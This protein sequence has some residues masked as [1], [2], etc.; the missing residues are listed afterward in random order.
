[1]TGEQA[2][3]PGS[4]A[5]RGVPGTR[6][7]GARRSG[8][9]DATVSGARR[10]ALAAKAAR[11]VSAAR[12]SSLAGA[13]VGV[14]PAWLVSRLVVLGTLALAHVLVDRLHP[15]VAG[16]AARVHGGLLGWDAG[17]YEAIARSGYRPSAPGSLRF[18]P[19]VPL[20]ARALGALPGVGAGTA[21]LV[22]ANAS[23]WLGLAVVLLLVTR[24][25]GDGGTARRAVW[26]LAL[27]PA[28]FTF[29]MGYAE[30]TLLVLVA[31]TFLLLRRGRWWWAAATGL[32]AGLTRPIG[33]LLVVPAAI[34][35]TRGLWWGV[36][37]T[38]TAR[39]PS[40]RAAAVLGPLAGTGAYLAWVG[41]VFGDALLPLRV[42]QEGGHRGRLADPLRTL[43]H[44]TLEA[45]HGHHVGSALH[46]PWVLLAVALLVVSARR[47]PASYAAFAGAVL[48]LA[49]TASNLD[50]FER[51]ALS[52]IP[53]TLA[54]ASITAGGVV[55]R[56]VLVL[57]A[58]SLV[59]YALLAFVNLYVP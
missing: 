2:P 39:A 11:A 43:A 54:A 9:V 1:M 57:L 48:L 10:S 45:L 13:L 15:A 20:A 14:A 6:F 8:P 35:A 5:D 21:L 32:L 56:T 34:E 55:E 26:Y 41:A 49:L 16:A 23:A 46:V 29:V 18:F 52:A 3:A 59:G 31:A 17:W 4:L 28:A 25:T 37:A 12:R 33:A 51:Y 19:L 58:T 24:E 50:S 7:P 36:R 53:L 44:N 47:W 42:Q 38:G 30:A 40:G 22:V 27:A